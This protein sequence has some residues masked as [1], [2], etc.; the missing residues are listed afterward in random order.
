MWQVR[1][2]SSRPK[3][4]LEFGKRGTRLAMPK[5]ICAPDSLSLKPGSEATEGVLDS[6]VLGRP[7]C[8]PWAGLMG[9]E[10]M[11]AED[12]I[13]V[14]I[15]LYLAWKASLATDYEDSFLFNR[16]YVNPRSPLCL[17]KPE[18]LVRKA[19]THYHSHIG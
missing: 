11:K 18:G 12:C 2:L 19:Y 10:D 13:R 15:G 5:T 16:L 9:H 1:I 4:I 7:A 17:Y 8:Y 14:R 3:T 6:G